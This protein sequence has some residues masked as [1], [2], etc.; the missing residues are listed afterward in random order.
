MHAKRIMPSSGTHSKRYQTKSSPPNIEPASPTK[1]YL[2]QN[3]NAAA[4][5]W[6]RDL[7]A[8]EK[9]TKRKPE[10]INLCGDSSGV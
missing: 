3:W 1:Q 8:N 7:P 9:K 5:S 2:P 4:G 10:P 6:N